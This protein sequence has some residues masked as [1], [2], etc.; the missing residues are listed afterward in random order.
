MPIPDAGRAIAAITVASGSTP[1]SA[2]YAAFVLGLKVA[3]HDPLAA[4]F[5]A[6]EAERWVAD[7]TGMAPEQ[8]EVAYLKAVDGFLRGVG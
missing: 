2:A 3:L 8:V 6:A 4:R 1:E 5:M 7:R